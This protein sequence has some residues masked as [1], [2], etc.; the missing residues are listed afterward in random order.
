[1]N[2][3]RLKKCFVNRCLFGFEYI[4][5]LNFLIFGLVSL[6][7]NELFVIQFRG[8]FVIKVVIRK[9][10]FV[11]VSFFSKGAQTSFWRKNR[12]LLW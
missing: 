9:I 11:C 4:A 6:G 10:S 8:F 7:R 3:E 2:T 1:M 12:S 5:F